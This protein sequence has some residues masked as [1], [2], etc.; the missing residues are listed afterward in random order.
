MSK[1]SLTSF[2]DRST[3]KK[4]SVSIVSHGQSN[5]IRPL[6]EDISRL[7]LQGLELLLTI[8]IPED[9]TPYQNTGLSII[10]IRNQRP[11][12]FGENHNNAFSLSVGDLFVVV[13]PDIRLTEFNFDILCESMNMNF[14][15]VAAPLVVNS[16]GKVQLTARK[17]P[18]TIALLERL[19][20]IKSSSHY[21]V[22]G[23]SYTV[24]W[25]AGMFMLFRREAFAAVKGFDDDRF[26]LYY[27]DVDIC[28]RLKLAGWD[29]LFDPRTRVEHDAQRASHRSLKY[30]IWH[31]TSATR[32]LTGL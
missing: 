2:A 29:V 21:P 18:T 25:V 27:E 11:R 14:V 30:L 20:G 31:L 23:N 19:L 4:I 15:G 9:E 8:N 6:L 1:S 5:L 26:F 13:N 3:S 7:Q 12:G 28:R 24:D 10:F 17:F 32:Y 22:G 16:S